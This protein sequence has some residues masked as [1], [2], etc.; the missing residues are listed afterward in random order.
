MGHFRFR[1]SIGNKFL[2]LNISKTGFS[3]TGGVPGAHINADLS[4]RRKQPF[5]NT[6]SIPGTGVSYRTSPYGPGPTRGSP[7]THTSDTGDT[8]SAGVN[9][10]SG[11]FG[12]S[13]TDAFLVV[14]GLVALALLL[15]FGG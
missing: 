12:W 6:F 13:G 2:R 7:A 5:V 1:R 3:I 10:W 11:T 15:I 14:L 4:K 8:G 9:R